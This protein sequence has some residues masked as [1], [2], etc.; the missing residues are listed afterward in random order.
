LLYILPHLALALTLYFTLGLAGMLWC[1]YVPMLV[2]YN[3]TWSINSICHMPRFGYRSFDT[4]DHSRN[5]FWIG[6]LGFGEGYHNNHHAQPRC[7]AHGLRW[8]EFDL[9]RYVIWLLEKCGLAWKVVWPA[10]EAKDSNA[11]SNKDATLLLASAKA[12]SSI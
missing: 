1:L 8:W 6:V 9:T 3:V 4:S 10:K 5:N 2:I 7:A 11:V 12:E